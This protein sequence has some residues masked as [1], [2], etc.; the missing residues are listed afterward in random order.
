MYMI[1]E[2]GSG[3]S[4]KMDYMAKLTLAL[5]SFMLILLFS[6][7][8]VLGSES[9]NGTAPYLLYS[10]FLTS[11]GIVIGI[12]LTWLNDPS[13]VISEIK[14][15]L[16]T[17]MPMLS[18]DEMAVID[19]LLSNNIS[20]P[21]S[22]SMWQAELVKQTGFSDSKASRLLSRMEKSGLI[23]RIRDGMGKR[24]ELN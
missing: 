8:F 7:P 20:S 2:K 3:Q 15:P 9:L 22:N 16:K 1:D 24:V 17:Q 10:L 14:K 19:I 12:S 18:A 11:V 6:F 4:V 23:R 13:R 5:G 21:T